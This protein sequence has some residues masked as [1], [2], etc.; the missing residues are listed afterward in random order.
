M[1]LLQTILTI[2]AISACFAL[3]DEG[4]KL[5]F[6]TEWQGERIT[7]PPAFAPDMKLKGIEEIRFAPGMFDP[8]SDS[9]FSYV[10]VFSFSQDQP[11]SEEMIKQETLTYYRGLAKSVLEGRGKEVDASKFKF[12]L[13][14]AK[15]ANATAA[16]VA[17]AKTVTQYAGKLDWI[18][19]FATAEPQVLHFEIQSWSDPATNR[20]Y[21]FVGTSPQEIGD[22]V[23][24]WKELRKIRSEFKVETGAVEAK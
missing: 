16:S 10:F 18:E 19:P 2:F 11:A 22:Q 4:E 15:E 6:K 1:K 12:E 9:F 7:L 24:I 23:A 8:K 21:L 13:K 14:K 17:D 20:N 3:A 5:V